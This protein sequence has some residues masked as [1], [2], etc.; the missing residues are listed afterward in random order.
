MLLGGVAFLALSASASA[1]GVID[2]IP[3]WDGTQSIQSWG[4]TNTATYGQTIT[5][6]AGQTRLSS[7][8][9]QLGQTSGTAPQ[10]Q[11]FVFQ[12]DATNQRITGSALFSS[13]VFTAPSGAAF[14]PVTINTG[15]VVLTPGQQ[16]VLFLS[17]SKSAAAGDCQL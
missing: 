8:T 13:S 5:P 1:Q 10:Y 12:W 14:T 9:F 7:F 17:T 16:Y 11:A 2:T 15:S 6:T 3:L 4:V